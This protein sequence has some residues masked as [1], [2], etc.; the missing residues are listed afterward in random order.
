LLKVCFLLGFIGWNLYLMWS[1]VNCRH[2][3]RHI[4]TIP[5]LFPPTLLYI[6]CIC[7]P[8]ISNDS[9][10]IFKIFPLSFTCRF[11]W[12]WGSLKFTSHFHELY[13]VSPFAPKLNVLT[14]VS[15]I[16]L[17][18][19][20]MHKWWIQSNHKRIFLF[21][22]SCGVGSQLC[23]RNINCKPHWLAICWMSRITVSI[24]R[25]CPDTLY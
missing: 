12:I 14:F 9:N 22:T 13:K 15:S 5:F 23:M 19:P 1:S 21:S 16:L 24:R 20:P 2:N 10:V 17:N 18:Q 11:I 25:Y 7:I 8:V 6:L 3:V 4:G